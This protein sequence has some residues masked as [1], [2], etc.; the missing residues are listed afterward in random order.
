VHQVCRRPESEFLQKGENSNAVVASKQ[1][2][3][4]QHDDEH[5]EI[6][7]E[8]FTNDRIQMLGAIVKM[9]LR[10]AAICFLLS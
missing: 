4:H 2:Q 10:Y 1:Q 9:V 8:F 7:T 5:G 3:P 6:E